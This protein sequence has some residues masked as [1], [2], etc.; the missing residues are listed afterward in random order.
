MHHKAT[1]TLYTTRLFIIPQ[2]YIH[3]MHHKT[4]HTLCN[5]RLFTLYAPQGYSHF[6]HH[7]AIQTLYTTMLSTLYAP[8]GYSHFMHHNA[9]H[10]LCTTRLFTRYTP[11]G[12]SHFMHHNLYT[13]K[14]LKRDSGKY[15]I[16]KASMILGTNKTL[17]PKLL[18]C[19]LTPVCSPGSKTWYTSCP[20]APVLVNLVSPFPFYHIHVRCNVPQ[21][22]V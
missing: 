20:L 5:T 3:F 6:M 4:I 19:L 11:Q 8:H 14:R 15:I 7:K 22:G 9:I 13:T 17:Y 12:Y 21:L 1:H 10:T 16:S 2:G 18:V